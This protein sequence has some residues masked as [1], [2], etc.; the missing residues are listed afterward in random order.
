MSGWMGWEIGNPGTAFYFHLSKSRH[1][2]V[3]CAWAHE[4]LFSPS[5]EGTPAAMAPLTFLSYFLKEQFI[6]F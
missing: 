5:H 4:M 2:T 1:T 6:D 3:S